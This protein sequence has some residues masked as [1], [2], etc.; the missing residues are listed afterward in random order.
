MKIPHVKDRYMVGNPGFKARFKP[1][2]SPDEIGKAIVRCLLW[3][4]I[5]YLMIDL[6]CH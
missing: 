6:I 4:A 3:I 2:V 5:L 1:S